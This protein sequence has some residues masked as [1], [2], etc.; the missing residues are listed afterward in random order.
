MGLGSLLGVTPSLSNKRSRFHIQPLRIDG[1]PDTVLG[2]KGLPFWPDTITDSKGATWEPKIVPGGSHPI[3]QFVA[4]T[5]RTIS[6]TLV[7]SHETQEV[8]PTIETEDVHNIDIAGA[9]AW[10]RGMIYPLYVSD[11]AEPPP[12]LFSIILISR[13]QI[14]YTLM[15]D[16]IPYHVSQYS[17]LIRKDNSIIF[18]VGYLS[19]TSGSYIIDSH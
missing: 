4:G 2:C 8:D 11:I 19:T 9:I 14:S 16:H 15:S 6:F 13:S 12:I 10:L 17:V 1:S 18:C 7:L 3:Y 5:D